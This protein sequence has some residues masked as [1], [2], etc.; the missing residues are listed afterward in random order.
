MTPP[1]PVS[2][3]ELRTVD[4]FDGIDDEQLGEWL[5]VAQLHEAAPGEL[6]VEEQDHVPGLILLLAGTAST[7]M[8]SRGRPEP[9]GRQVAPTWIGAIS[10]LTEDPLPVRIVAETPCRLAIVPTP[11]FLRL[12]F[13][14]RAIH[15]T[16]IR[17]IAPVTQR[18]TGIE[19]SRER[20]A[21]L[22]TMAAGLAHE[23]NNPAA[24]ARRAASQLQEE[25]AVVQ[26]TL[27]KFVKSGVERADAE[28]LVDLQQEALARARGATA[29]QTLD[30]SDAEDALLDLLDDL[31]IPEPWRLAE[32][33]A[34]AGV[35]REWLDRVAAHAG[36]AT[37]AALRWV[38][39]TLTI[40]RV[41]TEL[42]ESTDRIS[43][44][45]SAVKSYAYMDRGGLVDVDLHEGLETTL[46]V[47][48]HK[49]K[50]T[51]IS[52]QRD[53]DRTLPQMTVHGSELNQV[54]TNLLD[55]AIGALGESGTITI[56]TRSDGGYAIVEIGDDGPGIP[57]DVRDRIFD[58]F[59]TTKD[60]GFGTGLGLATARQIVVERH[61][62]L[63]SVDSR[64]GA[65]TFRVKL[66]ITQT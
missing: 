37:G 58:P 62:G 52:V 17:R 59:F 64:P 5:A 49:L 46:T 28:V 8:A 24:A 60:V 38:A 54:W 56:R 30:A 57:D 41:S 19:Q 1:A 65:T 16:V 21:S 47:L 14:Q 6:I 34:S 50:H 43:A 11:E 63:L 22:G 36:T 40:G 32:P 53:Y 15:Q 51:S 48:N 35:D 55:N 2:V 39:A 4:L 27:V 29:L 12:V 45:V 13:S 31:G 9:V 20:L 3:A 7:H 66:P 26:S 25:V 33:L 42:C 44:L 23:L 10:V 18:L 61:E